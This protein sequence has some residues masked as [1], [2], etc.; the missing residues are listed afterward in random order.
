MTTSNH[1]TNGHHYHHRHR[2]QRMAIA[3]NVLR[4]FRSAFAKTTKSLYRNGCATVTLIRHC[5]VPETKSGQCSCKP[6]CKGSPWASSATRLWALYIRIRTASPHQTPD[7]DSDAA[8]SLRHLSPRDLP[9]L[10]FFLCLA[11][12][13]ALRCAS[14]YT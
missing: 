4:S 2:N 13:T 11:I 12:I 1:A 10:Y 3:R 7:I 8:N 9:W 6:L 14:D 5:K